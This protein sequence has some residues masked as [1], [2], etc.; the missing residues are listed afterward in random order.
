M[1]AG[2]RTIFSDTAALESRK[3]SSIRSGDEMPK[4]G[5]PAVQVFI[6]IAVVGAF[7]YGFYCYHDQHT[8]LKRSEESGEKLKQ[9]TESLSAQLQ[10]LYEHKTRL[11]TAVSQEKEI[12]KKAKEDFDV[13]KK[14]LETKVEQQKS[15][16]ADL[17]QQVENLQKKQEETEAESA[18]TSEQYKEL[19]QENENTIANLKDD[20]ANVKRR[21]GDCYAKTK[22]RVDD[23][24]QNVEERAKPQIN[25]LE[26]DAQESNDLP[27]DDGNNAQQEN[28]QVAAPNVAKNQS[29]MARDVLVSRR[30]Y[31]PIAPVDNDADIAQRQESPK[32]VPAEVAKDEDYNDIEK[33]QNM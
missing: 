4:R 6:V 33:P 1:L 26:P 17:T 5:S 24:Q 30:P 28:M 32:S 16:I 31:Y 22:V 14:E 7:L 8:R 9:K 18:K 23:T 11:E 29:P 13:Q 19:Q 25:Q 15:N 21:L 27:A 20:L 2:V 3:K 12:T 10:V